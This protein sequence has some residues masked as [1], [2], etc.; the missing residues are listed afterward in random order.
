GG[1]SGAGPE[2][3]VGRREGMML[4]AP[5]PGRVGSVTSTQGE[6]SEVLLPGSVTVAATNCPGSTVPSNVV[7]KGTVPSSPVVTVSEPSSRSPSPKRDGLH[8]VLA[9]NSRA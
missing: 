9:K 6:N 7:E 5:S 2:T 3:S 1:A 4:T 8:T